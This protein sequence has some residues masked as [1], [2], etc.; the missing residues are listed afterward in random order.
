MIDGGM[1]LRPHLHNLLGLLDDAT[2]LDGLGE[3]VRGRLLDITILTRLDDLAHNLECWKS[4]VAII[5]PSISLKC[6]H[7]FGVLRGLW[8]KVECSFYLSGPVLPYQVPEIAE[9]A[10]ASTGICFEACTTNF[11]CP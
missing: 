5:T 7:F 11:A 3:Y 6:K 10:S 8:V 9:T 4:P 1:W 2:R